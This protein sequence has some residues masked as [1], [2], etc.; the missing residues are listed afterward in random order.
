MTNTLP[1]DNSRGWRRP[2]GKVVARSAVLA[3]LACVALQIWRPYFFL[4]DDNVVQWLP[5]MVEM[6]RNLH[7][8]KPVFVSASLFGGNYDWSGDAT[9][10]PFLNPLLPLLSPLARTSFYFALIDVITTIEFMA[11][12]ASFAAATLWLR[13]RH[14]IPIGDW[15]VVAVSLSYA[16][17]PLHLIYG[18]SW[19]GFI[20][21]QAAWPLIFVALQFS[22]VRN[23]IGVLS[24]AFAFA[25]FGGNLHPFGFLILGSVAWAL[26]FS[27]QQKSARP[28]VCLA[29][30]LGVVGIAAG[31]IV[32]PLLGE[33]SGTGQVRAFSTAI[34]SALNVTPLGLTASFLLG[35]LAG[36][37]GGPEFL[38]RAETVWKASVAYSVVN[39]CVVAMLVAGG[40]K[41]PRSRPVLLGV[42]ATILFVCRPAWLGD[43]VAMTPILRSTR[44]PFREITIL[45]F[46]VHLL[47]V[48][49]YHLLP[50]RVRRIGCLAALAP[51][52]LL[53]GANPPTLN[54]MELSRRLLVSGT[55]DE[56]WRALRPTLGQRP[57]LPCMDPRLMRESNEEVP[58]PLLPSQNLAALFGVVSA[59]GYS[60]SSAFL[61]DRS[62]PAPFSLSGMYTPENGRAYQA[63]FPHVRLTIL[64]QL[65][66]P[67]WSII[68]DGRERRLTLDPD[69]LQI[70][71]LPSP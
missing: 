17:A 9:I 66:P 42:A 46:L 20:N 6:A 4:T 54:P 43:L 18:A 49:N 1:G 21:A 55:A 56:Y 71:E 70:R 11:I 40:W 52:L 27:W 62:R 33:I 60:S 68:E 57:N 39:W 10:F 29:A 35:P 61:L 14:E 58:Y 8:G 44:W 47:F 3:L 63:M 26:Y 69:T 13:R 22:S 2:D 32:G 59:S 16:F 30:S 23:S 53:L 51:M 48:L 36:S 34:S 15:A 37:T 25:L 50:A 45:I 38:F 64:H 65:N 28:L 67:Q 7:E 24:A 41:N 5:P 12:A 31:A 19:T